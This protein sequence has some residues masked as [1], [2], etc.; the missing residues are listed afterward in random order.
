VAAN[1]HE[2]LRYWTHWETYLQPFHNMDA[3]L[4]N[5]PT[6]TCIDLLLGFACRVHRGDYG[7]GCQVRAGTVQVALRAVGMTFELEGLPN[8]TYRSE[9]K[10]WL[11]L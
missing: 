2:R 11:K 6:P 10:Y 7:D 3:I 8:P 5:V 1:H 9:G 4:T